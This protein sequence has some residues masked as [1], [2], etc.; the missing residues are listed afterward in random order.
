[1]ATLRGLRTYLLRHKLGLIMAFVFFI[2]TNSAALLGPLVLGR[3]I[4][5]LHNPRPH[6]SLLLYAALL[7]A[8]AALQGVMEFFAR[9]TNNRVSRQIEY[10]LRNDIFAHFQRLELAYFQQRTIGDLVARAINDLSAVRMFLGPG[11]N[12]LCNTVIIFTT[13]VLVM[14]HIDLRLTLYAGSA[15][16]LVTLVFVLLRHQ[17]ERRF[18]NVQDQ[19]GVIS[20]RAQENFSGIRAIR[21]YVQEEAEIASF[22]KLNAEYRRRSIAYARMSSLIWPSMATVAGISVVLLLWLGGNDVIDRR[23]TVGQF[24]Q[25]NA[26]IGQLT[27]P[28]IGLGWA[29]NLFQQGA[30]SWSRIDEVLSYRTAIADH[31]G[32]LPIEALGGAIEFRHVSFD[33]GAGDV[34][35]D[36]NLRI[37]AGQTVAIVGPTGSGKTTLVNLIPRVFE[38]QQGQVL[39][40]GVDVKQL[41]LAVLRRDVGYVPQESFLFSEPLAENVAYGV[42]GADRAAV[43][44]AA[45]IAQLSKDVQDFPNG[46]KTMVG[47]RG[48]TLSGGQK[49]RTA[50]A[51]AVTKNPTILILDDALSSVD[52]HTEEEILRRLRRFMAERTSLI[53]SHRISTVRNADLIVVLV[54]GRIVERGTHEQLVARGGHYAAMYRRQLL[55]EELQDEGELDSTTLDAGLPA[56]PRRERRS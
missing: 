43:E 10:E 50:I 19:F 37:E 23:I 42:P 3:A 44:A 45:E 31:P 52:T 35:H 49:Q 15:L 28:M 29:F 41:P 8:V 55:A 13:T 20:A 27:W 39:I 24:V 9:F 47:E 7:V 17:T 6:T 30:A 33:Y 34:L 2:F 14:A 25:F 36:V 56:G 53:I 26:Y 11:L 48:V 18:K 16:P 40:D 54:D 4:D 12:N 38:T 5:S 21:A 51:R 22:S 46:Y 32:T 1:M